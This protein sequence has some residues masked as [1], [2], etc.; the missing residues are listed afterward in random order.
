MEAVADELMALLRTHRLGNQL[1]VARARMV[2]WNTLAALAREL[3]DA[4]A[5]PPLD[6]LGVARVP[7]ARVSTKEK[8]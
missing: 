2:P 3:T 8:I 4:G 7:L 6:L 5:D 1:D